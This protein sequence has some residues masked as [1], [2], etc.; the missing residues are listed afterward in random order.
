MVIGMVGNSLK[1]IISRFMFSKVI[2]L[3]LIVS[4]FVF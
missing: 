4:L 1:L 2:N 3:K